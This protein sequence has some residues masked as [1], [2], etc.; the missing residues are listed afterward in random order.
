MGKK[1]FVTVFTRPGVTGIRQ[2]LGNEVIG[3]IL[4]S[5]PLCMTEKPVIS[6]RLRMSVF[7]LTFEHPINRFFQGNTIV[8]KNTS[9]F[10]Y[11]EGV[12]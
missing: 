11:I 8:H 9:I 10:W 6:S 3:E 12:A 7:T 1:S 5:K 4:C 2:E